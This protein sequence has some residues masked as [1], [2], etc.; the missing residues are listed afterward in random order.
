MMIPMLFNTEMVQPFSRR[1]L[2]RCKEFVRR[3]A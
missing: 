3:W 1:G 2:E